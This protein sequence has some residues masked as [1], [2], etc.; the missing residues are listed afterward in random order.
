MKNY[1]KPEIMSPIRDWTSL[2]ACKDFADA[3]YFGLSGISMRSNA[4]T[5][6][7]RNMKSFIDKS[8]SYGLLAYLT[9]NSVIYHT[10]MKRLETIMLAAKAAAVDAV[11]VWD[12]AAI[13]MAA[14]L[15]LKFIIS[16]QANISNIDS[17]LFYKQLGAYRVVLAREMTLKDIR[18]IK[19]NTDIEI[20][21]FVH[22]AMCMSIS[23]RCIL[24]AAMYS[25]SANCGS[26]SQPCRTEWTLTDD[27]Q[28]ELKY[29]GKHFMSAKDICMI[30]HTPELIKAGID[31]FKIEGRRRDPNYIE[32]TARL[33]REAVDSF[34]DKSFS[35]GKAQL[36]K[37]QL[38]AV[39]NRG[40]STGFYFGEPGSKGVGYDIANSISTEKR[41][42]AGLVV[43]YFSKVQVAEIKLVHRGLKT[44]EDIIIEGKTTYLKQGVDSI[45]QRNESCKRA[46]K[47]E[48]I[49]LKVLKPV[50]RNDKVFVLVRRS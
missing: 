3:V 27:R 31:S 28:R 49:G 10:D 14:R 7:L 34:F 18:R 12:P 6:T 26:C 15:K 1:K 11:I 19:K 37:S 44:G 13:M 20:E 43:N 24:S 21:T 25:K 46:A 35:A 50:R 29:T 39:Y 33:Y 8:H 16:T 36:W 47:G 40:F 23:G 41:V 9:L 5:F 30:E 4:G 45:E 42:L 48:N 32:T 2:E 22:G 17:A 38:E